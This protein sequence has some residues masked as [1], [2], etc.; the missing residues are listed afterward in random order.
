MARAQKRHE[1]GR[2]RR[3][4]RSA[5]VLIEQK[6]VEEEFLGILGL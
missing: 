1:G 3:Q 5:I 6:A 4:F 2:Q